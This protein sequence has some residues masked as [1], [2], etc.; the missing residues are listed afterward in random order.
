MFI[1]FACAIFSVCLVAVLAI[2]V[3]YVKNLKAINRKIQLEQT[4]GGFLFDHMNCAWC[5]WFEG[6]TF[7]QS[8]Q[9]FRELFQFD[10]NTS[11]HVNDVMSLFGES[12]FESF[13]RALSHLVDYGGE[14]TLQ[15]TL[16]DSSIVLE[17][18]GQCLKAPKQNTSIDDETFDQ[19]LYQRRIVMLI[20]NDV[21][22]SSQERLAQ[23]TQ[24]KEK[25][26]ELES[27][28]NIA[29]SIPMALWCRDSKGRVQYCNTIYAD[30][31]E[32][33]PHR[34]IAEN[35][36]FIEGQSKY[37]TYD[38][39]QLAIENGQ[40][41]VVRT[42]T[43]IAGQRRLME[44]SEI[45]LGD[46]CCTVGYALDV[47]EVEELEDEFLNHRKAFHEVLDQI[48]TP[49]AIYSAD[50]CLSFF[51]QSYVKLFD[52]DEAFLYSRP[53]L[54]EV[55][56]DL[57]AR[58]RLQEYQDF[59]GHKR[60]RMNL[61][62][63]LFQPIHEVA[64]Q[65][66]GR[67]LRL[68]IA[69]YPLGGLLYIFEDITDKL[70]L[71]RGYNTLMAVQRE[72]LDHLYEGVLVFGSDNRLRL[73][74]PAMGR[75]WHLSDEK[76]ASGRHINDV[77][78]DVSHLFNEQAESKIW[79]KRM[80]EIVSLRKPQKGTFVLRNDQVI[81]YAYVPLPDG[82]HM[83][84]FVDASDRW[85]FEQSLKERTVNLE[86]ADHL[87]TTFISHVSYELRSPLNTISGFSEIL[88]NQYF[89]PLNERQMDY[90]HGIRDSS[91]QLISLINDMID[92]ASIEAGTFN[93]QYQ[94]V[95]LEK[96]LTSVVNLVYNR[97]ND[98]GLELKIDNTCTHKVVSMDGRRLKH[99]L[100]NLLSTSIKF[101]PHGGR[102]YLKAEDGASGFL[103][104]SVEDSS[105]LDHAP[106]NKY[107][108]S[109]V[110]FALV[111]KLVNLHGGD[112]TVSSAEE[113]TLV[114]WTIPVEKASS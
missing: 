4:V 25:L 112:V 20:F 30:S 67:T 77:L 70:I 16:K 87:K 26:Q 43:V 75:I 37:T 13:Q 28:R 57:R 38:L 34:V 7:I 12:P 65:P 3:R 82:S 17:I 107:G 60:E 63:N 35:R 91:E 59:L 41:Q 27:L 8:S 113:G 78:K 56:E 110:G 64:D 79:R 42:H 51:N 68:M 83:M 106:Q 45:P 22:L 71:E 89:G 53:T 88:M 54:G 105:G 24:Q 15:N 47:T 23:Q 101:T 73:S 1:Y 92:L 84:S 99:A 98:Q 39:S 109:D 108:A 86:Q 33:T 19:L 94:E 50:T 9:K 72:T 6:D 74:N 69:P 76:R 80:T 36:E 93:L 81:D 31:L 10:A 52:F 114:S 11:V 14:F 32:T 85:R 104:I 111:Q 46:G 62:K 48:S 61:F 2:S 103:K 100:F 96:F 5:Y 44:V 58:R 102:I 55:L 90:C 97:A 40:Q 95:V 66:D 18:H 29:N 49:I 21:T